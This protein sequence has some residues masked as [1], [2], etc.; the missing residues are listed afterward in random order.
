MIRYGGASQRKSL[1][2]LRVDTGF[3]F[4]AETGEISNLNLIKDID[5][6]LQFMDSEISI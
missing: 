2:T 6:I 3:I 1:A 5:K 4:V